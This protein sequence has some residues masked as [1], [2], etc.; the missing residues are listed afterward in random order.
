MDFELN[1][2]AALALQI[3]RLMRRFHSDLH[4]R[5]L[6]VD[7]EKV[8]PIGGMILYVISENSPITA[9][10]ISVMLGRDKSQISR[11]V[12][13]LIK[14]GL[15]Q[16]TAAAGDARSFELYLSQKVALQLAAFNGAMVETTKSLL[17]H[18]DGAEIEQFSELLAKI[19]MTRTLTE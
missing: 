1:D 17:A 4:P 11:I 19:L 12:S 5:A 13:L 9:H 15:V 6:R 2:E 8:G 16:K 7:H 3:D 10:D 14:K 18:L